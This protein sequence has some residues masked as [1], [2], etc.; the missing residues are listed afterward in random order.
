[1]PRLSG[2]PVPQYRLHKPSGR[3]IVTLNKQDFYLGEYGTEESKQAYNA[4]ISEWLAND[5]QPL[6]KHKHPKSKGL[7]LAELC[8]GYLKFAETY[9]QKN[10]Q[11]TDEVTC[12]KQMIRRVRSHY[13][14]VPACEFGPAQLKAIRQGLHE[15]DLSLR[16]INA[17]IGRIRRMFSWAVD[18]E[19]VPGEVH[20]RL[21]R[22][23]D[24]QPGRCPARLAKPKGIVKKA[25][26]QAVLPHV[27]RQVR[28]MIGLQLLIGCRPEEIWKFLFP[29]G[30]GL[31][32]A[33]FRAP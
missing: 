24:W 28:A 9:Y 13:G 25:E 14:H 11:P 30:I 27:S 2:S 10:G 18:E 16:Y 3:A 17:C 15:E 20:Y 6:G 8:L 5:R 29:I 33:R 4:L 12:I 31:V 22:V 26:V 32:S 19:L 1:M 21:T 23:R 7:S